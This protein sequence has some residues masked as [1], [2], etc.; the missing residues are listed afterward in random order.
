[1]PVTSVD[2]D[3]EKLTMVIVADFAV[4]VRRLW[5]AYADPRQLE[6]FWG[7]PTWPAT[8]DRHD[9]TPGGRSEYYMTGPDGSRA[10]GYW[11]YLSVQEG[12]FFEVIDGFSHDDGTPNTGMP[13][14][15]AEFTF[16]ETETG[17]RLRNTTYFNSLEELEQLV[18]MGMEEGTTSAMGQMDEV[19]A[20][21]RTFAADRSTQAQH[22]TDTRVRIS[23]V[24]RGTPQQIWDAHHDPEL[25]RQWCVGPD[26]WAMTEC[27]VASA[28]GDR[29]RYGYAPVGD[30][31]GE[32]FA[33]TGELLESAAPVREVFLETMEGVDG[34]P[35]HNEQ[36]L[37][38]VEGGTLLVLV[39]T[40]ES[41][42]MRDMI[43]GTGMTDGMEASYE[44][45]EAK[46][47]VAS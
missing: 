2:K 31:E 28:P 43:L 20:D 1:M 3:L 41:R 33:L 11:E 19:L 39:I 45:L 15:R 5:D 34:P 22:L 17:S 47:L 40:Y 36:T 37:T 27:T 6:R 26:G 23:R 9:L 13:T 38:P 18:D 7:P 21:L 35:T 46:V 32:P 8:F 12:R 16:E 30:V 42:E 25:L 44:R 24:L 10:A 14:M 29:Y 4:P